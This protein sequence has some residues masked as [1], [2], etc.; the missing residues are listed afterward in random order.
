MDNTN[1]KSNSNTEKLQKYVSASG[2]MSRRKAEEEI[3]KGMFKINGK[4]A[5][6]GD[7]VGKFDSVFYKNKKLQINKKKIYILLNKPRRVIS[8]LSDPE[9]RKTIKDILPIKE[10]IYPVGRLDYDTTGL[11]LVTNDGEI[12][13]KLLHPSNEIERVY[14]AKLQKELTS[15]QLQLLNSNEFFL[16]GQRSKQNVEKIDDLTYKVTLREGRYH[17]VKNL[18]IA[19]ENKVLSLHRKQFACFND[20]NLRVGKWKFLSDDEVKKLKAITQ[21]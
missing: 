12:T 17:H 6:L 16:D 10:Y 18:F 4:V 3:Q 2:L 7:R 11:L 1:N 20:D 8:T 9:G 19:V 21:K 14:I 13:N 5:T 15:E